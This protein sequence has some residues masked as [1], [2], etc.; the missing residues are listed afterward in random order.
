MTNWLVFVESNTSGTGRL[1]AKAAREQGLTPVLLSLD[2]ARYPYVIEDNLLTVEVDTRD[3][4]SV[5]AAYRK[6]ATDGI[7]AGITSS[8][9]YYIAMAASIAEQMRLPGPEP[10]AIQRCRDKA[11]QRYQLRKDNIPVPDF[12]LASSPIAAGEFAQRIG[13]P[14]VVKPVSGSGS[15]GVRFCRNREQVLAHATHLL[16]Q[17]ANERGSAAAA[18]IL[19]EA[20]AG[21]TE[22]SVE[23]FGLEVVGITRK[24][25]GAL[26]NFVEMGH[27]HP[28][29]LSAEEREAMERVVRETL[30]SLGLGWGP[31]H[32][33][34]KLTEK[35]PVIIEVN[36]RLAGGFIPELVRFSCGVDLIRETI[37]FVTSKEVSLT[38][39]YQRYS[40]IRFLLPEEEGIISGICGIEE[41]KA[42]SGVE[43]VMLYKP[44]GWMFRPQ[45]D[46]RDRIGHV[47]ACGNSPGEALEAVEEAMRKITINVSQAPSNFGDQ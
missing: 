14:L 2:A 16:E 35:G 9:E 28:A 8:S 36:P 33:E 7:V 21:G 27:D 39:K 31:A 25:L 15:I 26:P 42:V 6:L 30:K 1:F 19:I 23:T 11:W 34:L 45:G 46:F 22:Y 4:H 29:I 38:K 24:Y 3:Q 40:S 18:Q 37:R 44:N 47:L 17:T 13:Y 32:T 12:Y 5:L 10:G 43:S 41:A 20:Y